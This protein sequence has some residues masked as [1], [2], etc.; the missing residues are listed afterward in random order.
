MINSLFL[1]L[2]LGAMAFLVVTFFLLMFVLNYLVFDKK[3]IEFSSDRQQIIEKGL[4]NKAPKDWV[5]EVAV[6]NALETDY[7]LSLVSWGSLSEEQKKQ[8]EQAKDHRIISE[9]TLGQNNL[10]TLAILK[11]SAQWVLK[12]DEAD[13]DGNDSTPDW[14][15]LGVLFFLM[16]SSLAVSLFFLIRRLTRPIGHLEKIALKLGD[17]DW[18]VR[19]DKDLL[20]PLD[21]LAKGFNHMA[22]ALNHTLQEQQV[23][24]GAIPH[25]LRSPLGRIRFALDMS[26]NTKTIKELRKDI[27]KIDNYVDDMQTTV[28]EI[29][30]LNRLQSQ[31]F[32]DVSPIDVCS[33]IDTRV[34]QQKEITPDISLSVDCSL[35]INNK[36]LLNNKI[37]GNASLLNRAIENLLNNAGRFAKNHIQVTVWQENNKTTIRV[38]DDGDGIAEEKL[39]TLFIPFSTIN[40][41]RNRNTGGIGL[42]LSIVKSIMKKHQGKVIASRNPKGGAR[43]EISW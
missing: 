1:R 39:S 16:F 23:L 35:F 31:Q 34:T 2:Y 13:S 7:T 29:L 22:D 26:R 12:I 15:N 40:Q 30:E 24:I 21:T 28:D 17:G 5:N 41:S 43:F 42:G 3:L 20:P 27:E 25:E 36:K 6:Y 19:A 14:L 33:I 38:D 37:L 32:V 11:G 9:N 4:K 8:L 10:Y 18:K